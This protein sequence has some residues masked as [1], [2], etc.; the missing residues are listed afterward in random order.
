MCGIASAP[1]S[2]GDSPQEG[3]VI[4]YPTH[5]LHV[6]NRVPRELPRAPETTQ[7][8]P[9]A[10][11]YPYRYDPASKTPPAPHAPA[12]ARAV[13][14][15]ARRRTGQRAQR[16]PLSANRQLGSAFT[17]EPINNRIFAQPFLT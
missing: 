16:K 14:R 1:R 13:K 5:E 7:D 6:N 11:A 12:A 3:I 2:S 15:T 8:E 4:P 17:N 9:L 10:A